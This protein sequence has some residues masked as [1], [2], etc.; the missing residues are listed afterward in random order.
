MDNA[1]IHFDFNE[2][3]EDDIVLLSKED[4]K[5]DSYGNIITFIEIGSFNRP[6]DR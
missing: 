4:T 2:M 3:V 6:F 5:I 1:R